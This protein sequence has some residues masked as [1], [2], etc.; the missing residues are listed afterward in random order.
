MIE[1]DHVVCIR[2][3]YPNVLHLASWEHVFYVHLLQTKKKCV[4]PQRWPLVTVLA[5]TFPDLNHEKQRTA[6][7]STWEARGLQ[8]EDSQFGL[9]FVS[10]S[11]RGCVF[12][13]LPHQGALQA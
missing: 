9:I 1:F 10:P 4:K 3:V 5:T 2:M 11:S 6:G 7:I 8:F 12:A 13:N